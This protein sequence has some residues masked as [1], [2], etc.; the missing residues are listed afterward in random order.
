MYSPSSWN[1]LGLDGFETNFEDAKFII[2]P[3][4]YDST[5]SYR[6]GSRNGPRCI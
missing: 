2:I 6:P 4:P 5:V 1:F 3:V